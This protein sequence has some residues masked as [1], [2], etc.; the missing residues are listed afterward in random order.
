MK[1]IR[2][3]TQLNLINPNG[4]GRPAI[5]DVGI[6]HISRPRIKRL[7]ALHLTIKVR[8]NKADI[9]SKKILEA[10][11]HAIKR[12]RLKKLKIIHYTL[13]YNHV[14]LLVECNDNNILHLGMQALGI[15]F[16]KAINKIKSLSGGVYKHRYHFRKL[17]TRRELK[18]VFHYIINNGKKHKRATSMIDPYNSLVAENR[19]PA[20]IEKIIKKN[21]FLFKLR[22]ELRKVLDIGSL[23]GMG[24]EY[25]WSKLE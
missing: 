6:R 1:K 9:K 4:A 11:H 25:L 24:I 7:T 3:N 2:K 21:P 14:H 12:A 20:D 19:I 23:Y 13:E 15:S 5:N 18:N 22:G 8:A 17:A 10:L 16:S